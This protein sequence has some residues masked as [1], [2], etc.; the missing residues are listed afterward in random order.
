MDE[1]HFYVRLELFVFGLFFKSLQKELP[2]SLVF[3]FK[4]NVFEESF[5]GGDGGL[6]DHAKLE[7][8]LLDSSGVLFKVGGQ[9]LKQFELKIVDL[10][11]MA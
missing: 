3:N 8:Q 6:I 1:P 4:L 9:V 10:L 11:G 2:E 5:T 7:K